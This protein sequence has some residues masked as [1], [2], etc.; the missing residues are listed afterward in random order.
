[1][2]ID[3]QKNE[4]KLRKKLDIKEKEIFKLQSKLNIMAYNNKMHNKEY[5]NNVKSDKNINNNSSFYGKDD[6]LKEYKKYQIMKIYQIIIILMKM[7]QK[8]K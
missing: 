7:I 6:T 3:I 4:R 1:M 5:S 2:K 8:I